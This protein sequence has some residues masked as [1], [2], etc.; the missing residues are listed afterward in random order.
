MPLAGYGVLKASAQQRQLATSSSPHYQLLCE[1]AGEP[2]R[3]AVN[4]RSQTAPSEVEYAVISPF[5]HPL[6]AR[7]DALADGWHAL[8]PG[9]DTGGLDLIRGNLAQP[10]EFK[11]LPLAQAGPGNDLNDLFDFHLQPLLGDASARV[12]AFGQRWDD[13]AAD[14]YFGFKPG[15]GVHDIHENQGNSGQFTGDD[16]V[17]QDGGLVLHAGGAWTAI[18]LRFQSQAWHTDDQTGHI[19]PGGGGGAPPAADP[20]LRIVAAAVNPPAPLPSTSS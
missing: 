5:A 9:P 16:G 19:L 6:T 8:A 14:P 17:W 20:G 10:G 4:A 13:G 18:L 12:F 11:P 3:I 15:R 1:A 7:V 2:Y